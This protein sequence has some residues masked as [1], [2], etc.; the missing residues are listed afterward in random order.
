MVEKRGAGRDLVFGG[1]GG[2]CNVNRQKPLWGG[3]LGP[4][5]PGHV[6]YVQ[7]ICSLTG[8]AINVKTPHATKLRSGFNLF[9]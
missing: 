1:E 8:E 2:A 5:T 4:G 7:Q 3:I 9:K 6:G